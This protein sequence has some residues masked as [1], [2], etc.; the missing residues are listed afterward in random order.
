MSIKVLSRNV[1]RDSKYEIAKIFAIIM[2]VLSHVANQ[3]EI[4]AYAFSF[5]GV[6]KAFS[7][8][9]GQIGNGIFVISSCY[10]LS[11]KISM[12]KWL[13]LYFQTL[14]YSLVFLVFFALIEPKAISI[15][16]IIKSFL[17]IA[18]ANNWFISAYLLFVPIVP[19]LNLLHQ[20][21]SMKNF[22]YLTLG[23]S[24]LYV[25]APSVIGNRYFASPLF[26]FVATYLIV[27][28]LRDLNMCKNIPSSILKISIILGTLLV[29][30]FIII[31]NFLG[32]YF[33]L[34]YGKTFFWQFYYCV[35][36]M[37][38]NLAIFELTRRAKSW[39]SRIIN[40]IA[41]SSLGIYLIHNN[42][43]IV[44]N[45]KFSTW[46]AFLDCFSIVPRYVLTTLLVFGVSLFVEKARQIFLEP[47]Q[48]IIVTTMIN[49]VLHPIARRI[50]RHFRPKNL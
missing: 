3:S 14:F 33:P 37:G 39:N 23:F 20:N 5:E 17:P 34:F 29:L 22:G 10:F 11:S 49:K 43:L 47:I 26:G 41:S 9:L 45:Q 36:L 24:M 21:T 2:I 13:S 12:E 27:I 6:F 46:F 8:Y 48:G 32:Q 35:P 19:F 1:N 42:I 16:V 7:V 30:F 31:V 28:L 38:V 18:F 40:S 25:V 15:Y 50:E 44:E 4:N